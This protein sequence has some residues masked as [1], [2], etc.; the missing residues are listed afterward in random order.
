MFPFALGEWQ[1]VD[2]LSLISFMNILMVNPSHPDK[3]HISAVRAWRFSQELAKRGHRV[4]LLTVESPKS[5]QSRRTFADS[6]DWSKP[7]VMEVKAASVAESTHFIAA[8]KIKTVWDMV[9]HG[10]A[11]HN[12]VRKALEK[13]LQELPLRPDIVW[14]TFGQM[15]AVIGGSRI[16]SSLG[17]PWVLDIKDNWE[18]YVPLGLRRFM[19]W[20]T[21][22]AS[23]VTS[24]ALFTADKVKKWQHRT[25]TVIYSGVD[26]AF[27]H[28][29][30]ASSAD[31]IF[32]INIVGGLYFEQHLK[33][34]LYGIQLWV[35]TLDSE[36]R[37]RVRLHY[38]GG[39]VQRFSEVSSQLTQNIVTKVMGYLPV[40]D[41]AAHCR[42]A[43]VNA[44]VANRFGFH[45]KLLE[46]LACD[47]PVMACPA[48]S[49]ESRRL[50]RDV[51]GVL[52]EVADSSSVLFSLARIFETWR[53]KKSQQ[54]DPRLQRRYGWPEQAGMLER[55][56]IKATGLNR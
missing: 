31:S 44:Y 49:D 24:N 30:E 5:S 32:T 11:Q 9:R 51:G 39:D 19:V 33:T 29:A 8:R 43:A 22:G 20:R 37:G 6:H 36:E 4:V 10:G 42:E 12:W 53:N 1:Y 17:I 21:H 27:F 45:H 52:L 55:V 13:F 48:E 54:V 15:E 3:P 25:A 40:N 28:S 47:C 34:L 16:A 2:A 50:A 46:L 14:C 26:E 35:E 56:L 18:L 7:L 41:M 23:A 38:L